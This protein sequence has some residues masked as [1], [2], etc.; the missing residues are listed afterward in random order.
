MKPQNIV[1]VG[2]MATGKTTVGKLLAKQLGYTFLDTD[3]YIE[4]KTGTKVQ[5]IFQ[6]WGEA[7]FRQLEMET[8]LELSTL[9]NHVIATGGGM[10][11]NPVNQ[12]GLLELGLVIHLAAEG[13]WIINNLENSKTV[14]PLLTTKDYKQRVYKLLEERTP[15]YLMAHLTIDVKNKS[16]FEIVK[17][18]IENYSN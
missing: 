14:R 15:S 10:F 11:I 1:L 9:K 6:R 5:D 13:D 3:H 2:M 4:A 18:I 17:E 8:V 7:T 16:P 12:G